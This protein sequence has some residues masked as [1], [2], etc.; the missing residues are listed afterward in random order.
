M[1]EDR[2]SLIKVNKSNLSKKE[3]QA[4]LKAV[5]EY[6]NEMCAKLKIT[7]NDY[8]KIYSEIRKNGMRTKFWG[9]RNDVFV[10]VQKY[11]KKN[12]YV[13]VGDNLYW[14]DVNQCDIRKPQL[15]L[16]MADFVNIKF[17]YTSKCK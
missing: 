10:K 3:Y 13:K 16:G 2:E 17:T 5:I 1:T 4:L 8:Y 7:S 12:L 14:A 15:H 11:I 6:R 9:A